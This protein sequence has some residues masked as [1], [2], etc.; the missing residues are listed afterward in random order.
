MRLRI[1]YHNTPALLPLRE[2]NLLR[3]VESPVGFR[4]QSCSA[5]PRIAAYR[6]SGSTILKALVV[7]LFVATGIGFFW[8]N[9]PSWGFY[10]TLLLGFGTVEAMARA[11]NYKRGNDLQMAAYGV[12]LIGLIVS[13]YTIII[14][15]NSS[16]QF[17]FDNFSNI[18]VRS[19]LYLRLVPDLVFMAIPFGIAYIRFR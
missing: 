5:G 8:G 13:R 12:I 19:A 10:M 16:V 4:C 17:V 7:G 6:T 9:F 3:M 14:D 18:G 11:S 1:R 2:T 15:N